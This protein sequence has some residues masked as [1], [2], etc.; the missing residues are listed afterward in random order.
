MTKK[1]TAKHKYLVEPD[2]NEGK[3]RAIRCENKLTVGQMARY[4]HIPQRTLEDWELGNRKMTPYLFELILYKLT[5]EGFRIP[6]RQ[7]K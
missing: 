3:L 6:E 2:S 4:L 1:I 5:N 7:D